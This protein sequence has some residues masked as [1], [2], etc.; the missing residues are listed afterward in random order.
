MKQLYLSKDISNLIKILS[1][2]LVALHH[3]AQYICGNN[4]SQS[5]VYKLLSSQGGYLGVALFFFLSGYGLMESEK[6][7]H[8]SFNIFFKNRILKILLPV[9]FV[10]ILWLPVYLCVMGNI[11]FG[12]LLVGGGRLLLFDFNDGV[13]WFVK[14][15]LM[16]YGCFFIFSHYYRSRPLVAWGIFVLTSILVYWIT[17][18]VIGTYAP[19]SIPLFLLGV[20]ASEN[21]GVV[22]GAFNYTFIPLIGCCAIGY[23][24]STDTMLFLHLLVNYVGIAILLYIFTRRTINCHIPAFLGSVSFDIYLTHNKVLTLLIIYAHHISLFL[25]GSLTIISSLLLYYTRKKLKI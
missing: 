25:F 14:V 8:L 1:A 17:N 19:I 7:K 4:L 20:Y 23:I 16:L 9:L 12:T 21:K 15:L 24:I 3:Y 6:Q 2:I 5:I 18:Q 11:S 13:L 22:W 10:S